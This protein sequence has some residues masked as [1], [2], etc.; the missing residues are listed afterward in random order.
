[1]PEPGVAMDEVCSEAALVSWWGRRGGRAFF[2]TKQS[3][4]FCFYFRANPRLRYLVEQGLVNRLFI[5]HLSLALLQNNH[6]E[7]LRL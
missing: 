6:G 4:I 3:I 5:S 7:K 2:L 1:M